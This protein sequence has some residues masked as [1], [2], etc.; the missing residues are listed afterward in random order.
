MYWT[1]RDGKQIRMS[2]M[3]T[4]HIKNCLRMLERGVFDQDKIEKY[5][6]LVQELRSR[7]EQFLPIYIEDSE[8][9]RWGML[10]HDWEED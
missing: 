1:T 6:S 4:Q 9:S 5:E 7:G 2:D 8:V 3:T 10:D